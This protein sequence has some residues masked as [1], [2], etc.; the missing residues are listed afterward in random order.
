M[1]EKRF[2]PCAWWPAMLTLEQTRELLESR[3]GV[4]R[5]TAALRNVLYDLGLKPWKNVKRKTYRGVVGYYDPLV[6]WAVITAVESPVQRST[7]H[8]RMADA[9]RR[10]SEAVWGDFPGG[11]GQVSESAINEWDWRVQSTAVHLFVSDPRHGLHPWRLSE[12]RS[13]GLTAHTMD[14]PDCLDATFEIYLEALSAAREVVGKRKSLDRLASINASRMD[15][16]L[17]SLASFGVLKAN[18][19][20]LGP[21][22][23]V[24]RNAAGKST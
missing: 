18:R 14:A 10:A 11:L 24:A 3:F 7:L 12:L 22:P 17:S 1:N 19:D 13:L 21:G 8:Q 23:Y 4:G 5:T 9:S 2:P 20:R 16:V 6:C 15:E